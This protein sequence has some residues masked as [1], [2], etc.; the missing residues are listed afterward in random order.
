MAIQF[1][2]GFYD[3]TDP[4]VVSIEWYTGILQPAT[5]SATGKNTESQCSLSMQCSI[6]SDLLLPGTGILAETYTVYIRLHG[7]NAGKWC[8]NTQE[9]Q[10]F[11]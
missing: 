6:H 3:E 4:A 7:M 1:L 5:G 11:L 10:V 8:G 2:K 9:M